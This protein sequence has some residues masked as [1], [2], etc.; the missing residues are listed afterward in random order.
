MKR[1]LA[2]LS[3]RYLKEL[4]RHLR[5]GPRA[6]LGSAH[7]LGRQAVALGL[8][9]LDVAKIH[10]RALVALEASSSS[11]GLSKRAE[12][13]FKESITP[14][15]RLHRAA[16]RSGLHLEQLDKKLNRRTVDLASSNRSLQKSIDR[17]K[18]VERA[19]KKSGGHFRQLLEE[20][21]RLQ[22]HL[23]KL[24][25]QILTAH[26]DK[27]KKISHDLQDEIAQTLL[28]INVRLLSLKK[29]AALNAEG[30]KKDIASTQRLVDQSV[31]SIKR[32]ARE[33]GKHHEA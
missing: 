5:R 16:L 4:K 27:R 20:S 12:L 32:F 3:E 22:K 25:H 9:T 11:N 6:G 1:K 23:Q 17:R 31:K 14:I 30:F 29:E 13:F 21:R 24:A 19:L 15:E 33:F 26:E 8:E 18:Q 28:G 10:E 7:G 2:S